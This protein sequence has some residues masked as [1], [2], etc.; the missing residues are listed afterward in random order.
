[1]AMLLVAAGTELVVAE[2]LA[3]EVAVDGAAAAIAAGSV[4][5]SAS[6]DAAMAGTIGLGLPAV[7]GSMVPTGLIRH[8]KGKGKGRR[9]LPED[10]PR[11]S[12][13]ITMWTP[14]NTTT[15]SP[16]GLAFEVSNVTSGD[17]CW[18]W[19]GSETRHRAE[20]LHFAVKREMNG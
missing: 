10:G 7:L 17:G 15:M 9:D 11:G 1:M 12:L 4:A 6:G 13:N 19:V 5:G 20:G 2:A 14:Y 16:H 8:G 18:H 3:A